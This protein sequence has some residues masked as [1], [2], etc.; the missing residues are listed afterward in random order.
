METI[1]FWRLLGS[2]AA[3]CAII[4]GLCVSGTAGAVPSYARQTGVAC[5]G[6]HTVFPELTPFGRAFKLNAY[7]IDNLPQVQGMRSPKDYDLLLNQAAPVSFMFQTSYTKT[8]TAL[9]DP[10]VV[11]AE[12][13]NGQLLFPQQASLFYA[14]RIAPGLGAFVQITYDSE[15]GNLHWDNTEIRYAK[16]LVGMS[17]AL[18]WGVTANNNPTVQDV[19]NSTPAWQ[20]PFDQKTSAA[21]VP[22]AATQ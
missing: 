14:G 5:Q 3:P 11:G 15:S 22:G 19:W 20:T 18:T 9:P 10:N 4:V 17:D 13:Q 16:Q 2:A 6:C 1:S 12:A 8:K 7:Q 21:P